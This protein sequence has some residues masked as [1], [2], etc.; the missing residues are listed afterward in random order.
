MM[1]AMATIHRAAW[2]VPVGTAPIRDG[3]VRCERGRIKEVGR[4][5]ALRDGGGRVV[6][7]HAAILCPALI[8]GHSHLELSHLAALGQEQ[9]YFPPGAITAW[10]G[11]LLAARE[12]SGAGLDP[13]IAARRAAV[14]MKSSGIVATADIGNDAVL[15]QLP[16]EAGLR[17]L[18]FL[19]LLGLAAE[20]GRL[21]E[22]RMA[23]LEES[24]ACTVHA[25]YSCHPD[26][27]RAV[28][29]RARAREQIFP[30]HVAESE[31]EMEFLASGRGAF[32]DFLQTRVGNPASSEKNGWRSSFT[33]PG[34]GAIEYLERLGVLDQRTLLI[35][36]IHLG[37]EEIDLVARRGA[38]VCLCPGSNRFLGVGKAKVSRMLAAGLAPAL[39]TD[40]LASNPVLDLWREMRLMREDHPG[41]AAAAVLA[42]ATA[43]GAAALGLRDFGSLAPGKSSL[44]IR[45]LPDGEVGD[46]IDEYLTTSVNSSQVGW[47]E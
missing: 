8:N 1:G 14:A 33:P 26:L 45:V 18:F 25:P 42:M 32:A 46:D 43:G 6:E 13:L 22:A 4:F 31:A 19:E 47:V 29:A 34:C 36:A 5:A 35:H 12:N 24:I 17:H 41:V 28:K 7:H 27:I 38:K 3:A 10:I 44:F 30:I 15:G 39:G 37:D 20:A 21:A 16:P 11:A 40:S 23:G 9:D 2:V